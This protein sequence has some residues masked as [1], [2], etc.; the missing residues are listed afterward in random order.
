V[1]A[2]MASFKTGRAVLA[3]VALGLYV[4]AVATLI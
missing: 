2:S 1:T 3:I 4:S